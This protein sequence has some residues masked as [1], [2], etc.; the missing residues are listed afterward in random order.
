MWRYWMTLEPSEYSAI[1]G[2]ENRLNPLIEFAKKLIGQ[3]EFSIGA[4]LPMLDELLPSENA[5]QMKKLTKTCY[6]ELAVSFK[7]FNNHIEV[8][9]K[10]GK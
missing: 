3:S 2:G 7:C 1:L 10:M 5:E 6:D 9:S 4:I 8:Q